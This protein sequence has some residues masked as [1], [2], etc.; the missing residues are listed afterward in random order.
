MCQHIV[1]C[2]AVLPHGHG[3]EREAFLHETFFKIFAE[4]H[5]S[6]FHEVY[7]AVGAGFPL[8]DTQLWVPLLKI[9]QFCSTST[10]AAPRWRAA[11]A[12]VSCVIWSSTSRLRAKK[13]ASCAEGEFG[14]NKRIF[15]GA[16]G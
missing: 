12:M 4:Q 3:F 2:V 11:A 15:G 9:T 7:G 8:S 6:T 5:F 10:T 13:V 14:R 16:V 1:K